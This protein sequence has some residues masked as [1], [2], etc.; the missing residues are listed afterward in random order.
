MDKG[1]TRGVPGRRVGLTP[2][3]ELDDLQMIAIAEKGFRPL[4]TGDNATIQFN[5]DTVG[6]HAQLFEQSAER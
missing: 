1:V 3:H 5:G 6:L 2:A 4:L